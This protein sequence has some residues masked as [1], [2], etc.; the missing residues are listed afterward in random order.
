VIFEPLLQNGGR[1]AQVRDEISSFGQADVDL[2][3]GFRSV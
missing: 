2:P 3:E 1:V